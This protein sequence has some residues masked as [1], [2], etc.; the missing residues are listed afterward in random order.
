MTK[1]KDQLIGLVDGM[2]DKGYDIC[3]QE[4]FPF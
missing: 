4:Y 2:I 1:M 3:A